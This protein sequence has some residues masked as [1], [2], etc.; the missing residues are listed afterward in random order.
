MMRTF[1]L[2]LAVCIFAT[3]CA[4]LP[5]VPDGSIAITADGMTIKK[6]GKEAQAIKECVEQ[7]RFQSRRPYIESS[8]TPGTL[9]VI[10]K[11]IQGCQKTLDVAMYSFTHPEIAQALID[12]KGRGVKVRVALDKTQASSKYS[13]HPVL[14]SSGIDVRISTKS[15]TMHHKFWIC[16]I[17]GKAE[18]GTGST[19]WTKNGVKRN[20][21]GVN[22]V[23]LRA[24]IE[25]H[26]VEFDRVW[27]ES[28]P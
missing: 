4:T 3:S 20:R 26:Q 19:N 24:A 9:P 7:S 14:A 27:G 17:K 15:A 10:L 5:D 16:D 8:F 28:A 18:L 22:V 23:R 13:V 1:I 2:V 6:G 25:P 21:E 12:A 11:S